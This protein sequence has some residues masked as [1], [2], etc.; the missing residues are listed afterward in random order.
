MD[1]FSNVSGLKL[2]SLKCNVLRSG[3]LKDTNI[4]Y[5]KD[6]KLQWSSKKDSAL[7]NVFYNDIANFLTDN[8]KK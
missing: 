1:K 3:S 7:G 8:L 2:N 6:K 5:L 4:S